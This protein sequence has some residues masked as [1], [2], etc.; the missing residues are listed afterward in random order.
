MTILSLIGTVE[1][2]GD[3]YLERSV[4]GVFSVC[5]CVCVCALSVL[6]AKWGEGAFI[7][8]SVHE[9]LIATSHK[10]TSLIVQEVG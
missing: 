10:W 7:F 1:W 3:K 8:V 2:T 5:V 4:S 9:R 6:V